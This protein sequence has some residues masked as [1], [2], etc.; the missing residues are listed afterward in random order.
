MIQKTLL[1]LAVAGVMASG[2]AFAQSAPLYIATLLNPSNGVTSGSF[3]ELTGAGTSVYNFSVGSSGLLDFNALFVSQVPMLSSYTLTNV[4]FDS[5]NF[6]KQYGND[7]T[8]VWSYSGTNISA[9]A[10]T[11]TL[12]ST[13]T[14][15]SGASTVGMINFTS[16]PTIVTPV[17]EP[18]TITMML[19]GLALVG[20]MQLRRKKKLELAG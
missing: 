18:A 9:G 3:S 1:A 8:S 16:T 11:L 6:T 19:A 20:G 17:P 2:S 12:T 14:L 10:H 15:A 4:A 5:N 7:F 13:G